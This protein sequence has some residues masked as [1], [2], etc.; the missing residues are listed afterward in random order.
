MKAVHRNGTRVI[1]IIPD[2]ERVSE[3]VSAA[4][5]ERLAELVSKHESLDG[6]ECEVSLS[7]VGQDEIRRLNA[8]YR[9]LDA[10]T[11][12]LSFPMYDGADAVRA[13]L[14]EKNPA[15]VLMGDVIIC[16]E[17]AEKQAIE[18]GHSSERET[19]FLFVHGLLHLFGYDHE[20]DALAAEAMRTAEEEIL[21]IAGLAG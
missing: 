2:E 7:F 19:G 15:P 9:S 17:I 8:L 10:P 11:D 3:D 6:F 16:G 14:A 18:Y 12:V 20:G 4:L 21:G 5:M 1:K 13:V